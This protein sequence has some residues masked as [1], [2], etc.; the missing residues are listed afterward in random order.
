MNGI[1]VRIISIIC[2]NKV[3]H[4]SKG[5]ESVLQQVN[6]GLIGEKCKTLAWFATLFHTL[7]YGRPMF[8]YGAHKDLFVFLNLQES[9]KMHWIYTS[10]WAMVEHMHGI[11]LEATKYVVGMTNYSS[12]TYD[13]INTIDNWS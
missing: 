3:D 12:L 9:P 10:N 1:L 5:M 2:N 6:N 4:A 8:D 11:V 13:E 7:K